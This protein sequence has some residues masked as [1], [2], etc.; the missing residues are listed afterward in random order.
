M[1]NDPIVPGH[2]KK[3][4]TNIFV[5]PLCTMT[6]YPISGCVDSLSMKPIHRLID[7]QK[8]SYLQPKK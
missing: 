6:F 2:P 1:K 7:F 3:L 5:E 4:R 8:K